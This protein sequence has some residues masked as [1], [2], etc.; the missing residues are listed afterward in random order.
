[1]KFSTP[2]LLTILLAPL[3]TTAC[4]QL[5]CNARIC[6]TSPEA[7]SET[8]CK[9]Y[10]QINGG[11]GTTKLVGRNGCGWDTIKQNDNP[12]SSDCGPGETLIQGDWAIWRAH[13]VMSVKEMGR[14]AFQTKGHFQGVGNSV[15]DCV[16]HE[17][18]DC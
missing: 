18:V 16:N 7:A 3:S 2:T 10:T 9:L 5:H 11:S 8:M 4:R 13:D 14:I 1:M 12:E 6:A 17:N 15:G